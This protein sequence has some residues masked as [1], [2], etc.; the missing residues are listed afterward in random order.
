MMVDS[1]SDLGITVDNVPL[2]A[3]AYVREY[4]K[5]KQEFIMRGFINIPCILD[6]HMCPHQELP[7]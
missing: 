2:G 6:T 7:V 1:E 3:D 5:Y 4:L